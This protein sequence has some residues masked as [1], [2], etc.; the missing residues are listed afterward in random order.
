VGHF[1]DNPGYKPKK[2]RQQGLSRRRLFFKQMPPLTERTPIGLS[3][4]G[5][6]YG[7]EN[8]PLLTSKISHLQ[9]PELHP[10]TVRDFVDNYVHKR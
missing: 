1:V 10:E 6:F 8:S 3:M 4:G 9:H 2:P 5:N 7:R